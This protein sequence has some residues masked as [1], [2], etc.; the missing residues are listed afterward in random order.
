MQLF[1][2]NRNSVSTLLAKTTARSSIT[3]YPPRRT[4]FSARRM[5]LSAP[6]E[7][8]WAA[9]LLTCRELAHYQ[10]DPRG[11]RRPG[12]APQAGVNPLSQMG[13]AVMSAGGKISGLSFD[14]VLQKLQVGLMIA[15]QLLIFLRPN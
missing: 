13:P 9:C 12:A 2:L 6:G 1:T 4:A 11:A 14:H 5:P 8:I 7:V 10:V 3:K 15:R